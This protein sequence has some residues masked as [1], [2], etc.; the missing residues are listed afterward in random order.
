MS[1]HGIDVS[2]HQSD[3]Y[4]LTGCDFVIVKATEGTTFTNPLHTA[5]VNRGRVHGLV[6]GHYHYA[7]GSNIEAQVNYFLKQAKPAREDFLALDWENPDMSN[8][9]KD[10]FLAILDSKVAN[11]VILYCNRDYW[12]NHDDTSRCADGLWI[13]QYNNN[14]G[15]PDITHPHLIH[16]YADKPLDLNQGTWANR[17]A[18]AAW[19][20]KVTSPKPPALPVVSLTHAVAAFRA[21]PKAKQ[22]HQTYPGGIKLIEHALVKVGMMHSSKYAEDGSAGTLSV[23]AYSDWQKYWSRKHNLGWKG[24]D[25]N[26]LPGMTSL[27]ALGD[28]SKLFKVGA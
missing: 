20:G 28:T 16:Q 5:Q 14:P 23:T 10:Q 7:S 4:P 25:I 26:G 13:A 21:D 24:A 18:M 9:E 11:R 22:G 17:A 1:V 6:M 15:H 27:K 2:S 3:S 19:A 12:V 8:A